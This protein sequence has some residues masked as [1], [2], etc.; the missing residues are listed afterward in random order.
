MPKP[1]RAGLLALLTLAGLLPGFGNA[2]IW[3]DGLLLNKRLVSTG[4]LS[5]WTEPSLTLVYRPLGLSFL[6]VERS[7]F[8]LRVWPYHLV[9]A[10]L[11]VA[12]TVL[13]WR[14]AERLIGETAG[15]AAGL[16][17]AVHPVHAEA[18]G[19]IY[20]QLELLAAI[21]AFCA[22]GLWFSAEQPG[23]RGANAKWA[24]ALLVAFCAYCAKESTLPL[25][26]LLIALRLFQLRRSDV[27]RDLLFLIPAFAYLALRSNAMGGLI[28][29]DS[30]VTAGYSAAQHVKASI[31]ALGEYLRLSLLPTGQTLYYGHLRFAI[32]GH[33]WEQAAWI[34]A[35]AMLWWCA[36]TG[37]RRLAWF[38]AA[39]FL[40]CLSLVLQLVP[41][42]VLVAE[43]CAYLAL[44][45]VCLLAGAN[46]AR[47]RPAWR[48]G[49][50]A[51]I[52]VA[53]I[54]A[55]GSTV[56]SWRDEESAMRAT[57]AS[58]PLSPMAHSWLAD[59][60]VRKWFE[61]H[62]G[63]PM[64]SETADEALREYRRS[65]DL[66]PDNS[67]AWAGIAQVRALSGNCEAAREAWR[68][69]GREGRNAAVEKCTD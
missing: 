60:I 32:L 41:S 20:G 44:F 21:L 13:A 53:G 51:A 37:M 40:I 62:P 57:I 6:Y 25:A 63:G 46:L 7:L 11:A 10:A 35:G 52:A 43:R 19:M 33:P 22:I 69:S 8:G 31:V 14:L 50:L 16:L 23:A 56:Y 66:V 28:G 29:E 3:D 4:F 59:A 65:L 17:F 30:G 12:A 1:V 39:W 34:G 48:Q 5:A 26:A 54:V 9:S 55:T 58:H 27:W 36:G 24:A 15:F 38:C 64:P 18:G 45:G 68:M 47:L 2:W 49:V 61:Q 67:D 42:G